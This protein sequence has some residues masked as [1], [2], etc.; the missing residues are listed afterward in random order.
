MILNCLGE[1]KNIIKLKLPTNCA[2]SLT[3]TTRLKKD[4]SSRIELFPN[5]NQGI[6]TIYACFESKI[7]EATLRIYN[8]TGT[9]VFQQTICSD[10]EIFQSQI[11]LNGIKTGVY[12]LHVGNLNEE[13]S[14][15][16]IIK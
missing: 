10:S 4:I 6:F 1:T 13:I 9:V 8:S 12:F 14:T 7:D 11:Q 16:L 2:E 5:P 15:K 3:T